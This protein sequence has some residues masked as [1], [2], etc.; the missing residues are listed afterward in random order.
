[1]QEHENSLLFSPEAQEAFW[2]EMHPDNRA[3]YEMFE[4]KESWTYQ[5]EELPELFLKTSDALPKVAQLPIE[6]KN[7]QVLVQLIPLLASM[8]LR[9]CLF[10]V[11]WLNE[12]VIDSPIG[13]GTLCYLEAVNIKNNEKDND[14]HELACAMVERISAIMRVRKAMGLFAQWP[15]KTQ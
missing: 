5:F 9:Q 14:H 10:A 13:W 3:C 2:A 8:P 12:K 15:L 11:H 6:S 1:M 7:Q 4:S